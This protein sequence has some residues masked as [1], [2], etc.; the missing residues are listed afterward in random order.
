MD[1]QQTEKRL[2]TLEANDLTIFKRLDKQDEAINDLHRLT[3]AVE[4]IAVKTDV[5]EEK[6]GG[7]DRRMVAV[8]KAPGEDLRYYRRMLVGYLITGVLGA[9]LGAVLSYFL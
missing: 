6:V 5:I 8:E 1:E 7:I 3:V 9:L 2:A 4:R